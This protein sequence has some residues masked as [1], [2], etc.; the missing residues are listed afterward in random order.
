M[1][2]GERPCCP[3]RI[4][5]QFGHLFTAIC[6]Y[7]GDLFAVFLPAMSRECFQ[8]FTQQLLEH[9]QKPTTLIL[10]RATAHQYAKLEKSINLIFLPT[11]CPELNP[12]ERFFKELRKELKCRVYESLSQVEQRIEHIL[13]KYWQDPTLLIQLTLFPFL[14]TQQ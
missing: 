8:L 13:Q 12:V 10:D 11:A 6:P 1:P 5:Y 4:G 14:N 3:I 7:Q 9:T 2:K